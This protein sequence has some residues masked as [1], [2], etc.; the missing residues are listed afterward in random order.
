MEIITVLTTKIVVDN[1]VHKV[2][3]AGGVLPGCLWCI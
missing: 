1:T 2:E 3:Q